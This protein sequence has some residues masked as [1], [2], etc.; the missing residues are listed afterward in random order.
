M[1][2]SY[3]HANIEGMNHPFTQYIIQT[4]PYSWKH[5]S[6]G[7]ISGN[8]PACIHNGE[9]RPD[10]KRRGGFNFENDNVIYHCFNCNYNC[11]WNPNITIP[12]KLENLLV[13]FGA[14]RNEIKKY[15]MIVFASKGETIVEK[16]Q[17]PEWQKVIK[18]WNTVEL[19]TN[20]KR[21]FDIEN[22][23]ID[24]YE[25]KSLL[26]LNNRQLLFHDDW[27]YADYKIYKKDFSNRVIL[28]LRYNKKIVGYAARSVEKKTATESKYLINIPKDYVFNLDNQTYNKKYVFVTE[29]FFDALQMDGVA[30]GSNELSQIQ[31][32]IVESIGKKIILVPDKNKAGK[33][34]IDSAI[35]RGWSI[36]FPP[37]EKDIIDVNDAVKRYGRL[38]TV[39][40]ALD[41]TVDNKLESKIKAQLWC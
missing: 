12:K 34:L 23:E 17:K 38:W 7:W 26:Y 36:S 24:S 1:T 8:C 2:K 41:F 29:G 32:E 40:T 37:W 21:L 16:Y 30:I 5:T 31:A 18:E 10:T 25:Y 28:P 22:I 35:E 3:I 39:K 19:P 20:S 27:Y 15:A 6:G 14:D 4:I 33:K 13:Y 9:S 11:S